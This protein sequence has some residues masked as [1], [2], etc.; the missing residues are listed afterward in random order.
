M[1]Q[2][3]RKV[4]RH[5][6]TRSCVALKELRDPGE[7]RAK[8]MSECMR[9]SEGFGEGARVVNADGDDQGSCLGRVSL[10]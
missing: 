5:S 1:C 8:A 10:R 6:D 2:G 4:T 3:S 7:S 9:G